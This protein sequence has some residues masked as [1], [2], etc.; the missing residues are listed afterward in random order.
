MYQRIIKNMNHY[1]NIFHLQ[2]NNLTE[3]SSYS[4]TLYFIFIYFISGVWTFN[5]TAYCEHPECYCNNMLVNDEII[6][7]EPY[8]YSSLETTGL[9]TF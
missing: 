6:K 3:E 9:Q 7:D 2:K 4:S 5:D 8:I 1:N